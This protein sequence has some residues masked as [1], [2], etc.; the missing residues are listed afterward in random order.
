MRLLN[1]IPEK[2]RFGYLLGL[3]VKRYR[4]RWNAW[5]LIGIGPILLVLLALW[6]LVRV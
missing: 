3:Q 5:I 4:R 2:E 1:N 6:Q